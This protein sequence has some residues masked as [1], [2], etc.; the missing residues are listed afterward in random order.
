[1]L[2]FKRFLTMSYNFVPNDRQ[3]ILDSN[4]ANKKELAHLYDLILDISKDM[5]D[6]LAIDSASSFNVK[7]HRSLQGDISS[8][9]LKDLALKTKTKLT[10]GNGSRGNAGAGN[11]GLAFE[12]ML[13]KDLGLYVR[14][15]S[16]NEDYKYKTFMKPF[17]KNVLSK[18]KEIDIVDMGALN[19]K[20]SL[21]FQN[22]RPYIMSPSISDIGSTV[23]DITVRTDGTP[24]HLSL[25][26]GGTVTFFNAGV[27]KIFPATD[28]KK[29][30]VKNKD[31]LALLE[32]LGIDPD[33]F[34]QV[35]ASYKGGSEKRNAPKK[36]VN[37]T[38]KINKN[39]LKNFLATGVG[40]GYYLV[41]A[42]SLQ[43]DNV[44]S[45]YL[46]KNT[47]LHGVTPKKVV[48]HYPVG[49]SA[50]RVDVEIDTPMFIFK[51]NIRNKQGG[52]FPSHVMCDYKMKGH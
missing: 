10:F 38:S 7:I 40:Y 4:F 42:K 48:V 22:G 8:D 47:V 23:T 29:G 26:M 25:K 36:L 13:S 12:K 2:S 27:T 45:E 39:E 34:G 5:K 43:Q 28:L 11:R 16:E 18:A 31:G 24:H 20:R 17:I 50:K 6:P 52:T 1:M 37:V 30:I 51:V 46:D 41:H 15:R 35:F 3:S 14:T 9:K 32:T 19:Q 44:I 21:G 49:G 33:T